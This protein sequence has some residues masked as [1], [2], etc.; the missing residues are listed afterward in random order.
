M[1]KL[2]QLKQQ[3]AEAFEAAEDKATIE[4]LAAINNSIK[5]AQ[6]ELDALTDKNAELIKS[7]K[8]LV[9][10]TSFK[11]DKKPADTVTGAPSLSFE[12]ALQE[13]MSKNK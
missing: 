7:Y 9:Q 12:E 1:G 10:H 2:E 11:D 3:V 8:D 4:K 6:E 5:E 13:F